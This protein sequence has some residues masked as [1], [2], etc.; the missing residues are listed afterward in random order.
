LVPHTSDRQGDKNV[1]TLRRTVPRCL[2]TGVV[3]KKQ[4]LF[5]T[6]GRPFAGGTNTLSDSGE[7]AGAICLKKP[8]GSKVVN[9]G[10]RASWNTTGRGL[11]WPDPNLYRRMAGRCNAERPV[12]FHPCPAAWPELARGRRDG[13]A[14]KIRGQLQ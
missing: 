2:A 4:L 7:P 9:S 10:E 3:G 5:R 12:P 11:V 14:P 6:P 8:N 1:R 13:L